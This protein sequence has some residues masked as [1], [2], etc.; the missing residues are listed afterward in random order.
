MRSSGQGKRL[1]DSAR[2]LV[3]PAI[4]EGETLVSFLFRLAIANHYEPP[5]LFI[6]HC[7]MKNRP[8]EIAGK[9][10]S[11]T[12]DPAIFTRLS[13]LTATPPT[14]LFDAT[15]HIFTELI[16][17]PDIQI[18]M[19]TLSTGESV[20][21]LGHGIAGKQLRSEHASQYCP[22]CL[23]EEAYF[24]LIWM[25][26]AISSCITHGCVLAI[27]CNK[28]GRGVGVL[29]I[30]RKKCKRCGY[31][32]KDTPTISIKGDEWGLYVQQTLHD[33]LSPSGQPIGHD[34]IQLP[35][36]PVPV[37]FR[38]LDGIRQ[39]LQSNPPMGF[40]HTLPGTESNSP[41]RTSLTRRRLTPTESY[42][43]YATAMKAL[44]SW[45]SGFHAFLDAF[46]GHMGDASTSI[47]KQ[48]FAL[49]HSNWLQGKWAHPH[50]RFVQKSYD[51][52]LLEKPI[53][54]N[55]LVQL[56]RYRHK[57]KS[58]GSYRYV[59]L[60]KA[61]HTLGTSTKAVRTLISAGH[62]ANVPPNDF[63]GNNGS[64]LLLR[65]EVATLSEKWKSTVSLKTVM[66]IVGLNRA[67]T[68]DLARAGMIK[69]VRG[70]SND[71][72]RV[73]R[74]DR[75]SVESYLNKILAQVKSPPPPGE[76]V[77]LT[78]AA[79]ITAN[80]GMSAAEILRCVALGEIAAF[81]HGHDDLSGLNNLRFRLNDIR[82]F[83]AKVEAKNGW[84]RKEE[85]MRRKQVSRKAVSTWIRRGLLCPAAVHNNIQYFDEVEVAC[86]C[87]EYL[88]LDEAAQYMD[89][90]T[91]TAWKW[92]KRERIIPVSGPG[93]DECKKY[94]FR[95]QVIDIF[96]PENRL[97]SSQAA[98][99]IG[100]SGSQL[101]V[102]VQTG[103]VQPISGPGIDKTGRFL[104]SRR[105]IL[106]LV[107]DRK[108][109]R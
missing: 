83:C 81:T 90:T 17:P 76:I 22:K 67:I 18:D 69:I 53:A 51:Q 38:V 79:H 31:N 57:R 80:V 46:G 36:Q 82:D 94:L 14:R 106:K 65:D 58:Q 84:I 16:T 15:A 89:I 87:E 8:S 34:S 95:L 86:L 98:E 92:V 7:F 25:P 93:I 50:F 88:D 54:A 48:R 103:K 96:K 12:Q 39:V 43:L 60:S 97:T 24:P 33:W 29:E 5:N 4:L 66:D 107:S 100:I 102:W 70:P 20:P 3:R 23:E 74:L 77:N 85:I 91:Q 11:L 68:L 6:R 62:L 64:I 28:C 42:I 49:L 32:L 59:S 40:L 61:A 109:D 47:I 41:L 44:S 108:Q 72:H 1:T 73:W 19:V 101:L 56:D 104:Y 63:S 27:G 13:R 35:D 52:Y 10:I 21:L 26:V 2:L 9:R 71:G 99:L 105:D 37:L 78:R 30:V 45:P 55:S 75:A